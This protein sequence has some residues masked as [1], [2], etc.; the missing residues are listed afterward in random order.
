MSFSSTTT[1][2]APENNRNLPTLH[3]SGRL[4]EFLIP[5]DIH[6]TDI[7]LAVPLLNPEGLSHFH[8]STVSALTTQLKASLASATC[9]PPTLFLMFA[10][11]GHSRMLYQTL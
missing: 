3:P 11:S 10:H 7:N 4:P 1:T 6:F 2:A 8:D 5:G 9:G